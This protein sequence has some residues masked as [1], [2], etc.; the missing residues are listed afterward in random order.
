MLT[1]FFSNS[2]PFHFIVV[3]LLLFAGWFIY[4]VQDVNEAFNYAE[5]AKSLLQNAVFL[6]LFLL[7]SFIIKKNRLT[8]SNSYAL[9]LFC[10]FILTIPILF[11]EPEAIF[12]L[13]FLLLALQRILSI[14]SKK[15]SG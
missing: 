14:S 5:I 12:S 3:S 6:L 10:C 8:Q 7:L 9:F 15:N 4:I 13:L 1:S 11:K 2:K